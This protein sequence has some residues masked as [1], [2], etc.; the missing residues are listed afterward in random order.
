MPVPE[1]GPGLRER[2]KAQVRTSIQSRALA[3]F[4]EQGYEATT[5]DQIIGGLDVSQRTFFRYFPT[6][7]S[8]VLDDDFDLV[9]VDELRGQPAELSLVDAMRGSL[10]S[11]FAHMNSE[12]QDDQRERLALVLAV[13]ELRAT[14]VVQLTQTMR[15]LGGAIAERTGRSADDFAVRTVSGAV[16]G[17]TMAVLEEVAERPDADTAVLMDEALVLLSAGLEIGPAREGPR[18]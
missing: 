12:Q 18:S 1:V 3:L 9:L 10:R 13:P 11:L 16:V 17:V 14:L 15:V 5:V 7:E 4:R 6:K 2:K 8:L